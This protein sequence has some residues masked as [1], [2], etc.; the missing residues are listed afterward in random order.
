M[1]AEVKFERLVDV[2]G[3]VF[4]HVQDTRAKNKHDSLSEL[5]RAAFGVFYMQSP[6][7]LA[8]Q[9]EMESRKGKGNV[10]SL[11]SSGRIASDEQIKNVLD[12]C[13]P[14]TLGVVYRYVITSLAA[15]AKLG[16]YEQQGRKLMALDG[17][18]YPTRS[19]VSRAVT[20][21]VITAW[22]ISTVS[23]CLCWCHQRVLRFYAWNPS[24]SCLK[25][26]TR[27]KTVRR[28]LPSAGW[29]LS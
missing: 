19:A 14:E 13:H 28:R 18:H 15:T 20:W 7:F 5:G 22:I 16:Q 26:D 21:N 1:I 8:W 9:R 25:M 10:Q 11:F 23:F 12:G 6:F 4:E 3:S 2:W 29:R 17:T 27:N 24:W